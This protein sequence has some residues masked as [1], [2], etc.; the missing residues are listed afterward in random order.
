[1]KRNAAVIVAFLGCALAGCQENLTLA[2]AQARCTKQ[3]GFL[4]IIHTQKITS[5]G[6]GPDIP[7]AGNCV[8]PSKFDIP[9]AGPKPA[10]AN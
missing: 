7:S 1:V 10:A 8:A 3:G 9:D 5:S 6:V 4:V 2:E